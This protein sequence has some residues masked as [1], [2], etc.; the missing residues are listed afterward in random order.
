MM[1]KEKIH[2]N[3]VVAKSNDLVP[4]LAK[5]DLQELRLI[6]YCL[7]HYDSRKPDNRKFT[8][9]V[10]ELA[11]I[12]PSMGEHTAYDVIKKAVI[13]IN[14]KPI[15]FRD[16][17]GQHLWTWF[18]G[19]SYREREGIFEFA[20]SQWIEPYLLALKERFNIF[21]LGDVH[22]FRAAS[23]WKLYENLN[24]YKYTGSWLATLD[25]LR[26]LL[27]VEGKHDRFDS[28]RQRLIDPALME[29]NEKSNL[30]VEYA[31][32]REGRK[33]TALR[34]FI[35]TKEKIYVHEPQHDKNMLL[36]LLLQAGIR[37]ETSE[38]LLAK[39]ISTGKEKHFLKKIPEM[40]NRWNEAKGPMARYLTG[41]LKSEIY[42]VNCDNRPYAEALRCRTE[43]NQMQI[44]CKVRL[45]GTAG[46]R[47]KC[48][49]CL[50]YMPPDEYGI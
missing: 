46:N 28:L 3:C 14:S 25:E 18:A 33:V 10:D 47:H 5:Y 16:E 19:F 49:M 39:I 34:F 12:F 7:A 21:R 50:H 31:K 41:A 38:K 24:I 32:E 37:Y 2:L 23:T 48:K 6:A 1:K 22:Q 4:K 36:R 30:S 20:I 13:D 27:D 42:D 29:I 35:R 44:K 11:E 9:R 17:Y 26:E 40:I 43:K 45:R 15:E 8:A